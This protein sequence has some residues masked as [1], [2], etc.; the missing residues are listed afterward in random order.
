MRALKSSG[1]SPH[2]SPLPEGE[3]IVRGF[4]KNMAL[5]F[6]VT[7]TLLPPQHLGQKIVFRRQLANLGMMVFARLIFRFGHSAVIV[8]YAV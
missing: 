1:Y 4:H 3:G 8:K 6:C 7:K 2:P 5:A